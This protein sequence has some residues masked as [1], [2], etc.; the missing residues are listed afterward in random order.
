LASRRVGT[1]TMAVRSDASPAATAERSSSGVVAR[2][3]SQP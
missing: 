2:A 1:T 3:K